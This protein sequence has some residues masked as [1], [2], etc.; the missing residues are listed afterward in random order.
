MTETTIVKQVAEPMASP[1]MTRDELDEQLA[2]Q[3]VA[4]VQ[5]QGT[6]LVGPDGL[7]GKLTN[8]VFETGLEAEMSE[9]PGYST[10]GGGRQ[11]QLPQRQ[12]IKQ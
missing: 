6:S 1:V 5:A 3:L 11:Q 10:R 9:H 7:R 2:K 8:L 4:H 12:P